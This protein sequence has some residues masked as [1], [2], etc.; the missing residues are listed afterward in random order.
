MVGI[1]NYYCGN[2]AK[3]LKL[4]HD[5]YKDLDRISRHYPSLSHQEEMVYKYASEH[6]L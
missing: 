3:M 2:I 6:L 1:D 5:F 4:T